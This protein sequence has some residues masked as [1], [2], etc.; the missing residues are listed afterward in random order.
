VLERV[1]RRLLIA[2]LFSFVVLLF[3]PVFFWSVEH[4]RNDDVHSIGDAYGWLFRT[5]F[6]NSTP[7]KLRTQFGFISY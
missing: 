7:Y 3:A 6:E 2:T 4:G 5:L 1:N